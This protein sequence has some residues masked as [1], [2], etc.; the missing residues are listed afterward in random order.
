MTN[1]DRIRSMTD[2]QL[3]QSKM[4]RCEECVYLKFVRA[5][6]PW[7]CVKLGWDCKD[8]KMRWLGQEERK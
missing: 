5:D 4:L 3:A 2:E 1:G 8:G 6:D 7:H